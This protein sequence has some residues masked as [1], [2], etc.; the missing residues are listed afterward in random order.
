MQTWIDR[1]RY[2]AFMIEI[3]DRS[4]RWTQEGVP[5]VEVN[6]NDFSLHVDGQHVRLDV[7]LIM[8]HG[9]PGEDGLLQSYLDMLR[10]PYT[11]CSAFVSA[12]TF[13]KFAC[14]AF[15]AH[16]TS[17]AMANAVLVRSADDV[18]VPSIV[19]K[20][21]LPLFVKPNADGSSFGISK[22]KTAEELLPAIQKTL[23]EGSREVI[24]EEFI[25]G[26]EITNGAMFLN[27]ELTVL[28]ITEIV[29]KND[30]FDYKA[31][32]QGHSNE[33]TPAR[34]SEEIT[35]AVQQQTAQIYRQLG[36]AGIVR[37]D[38]IV[39]NNLPYFLEINTVPG[40]SRA[41]IIP[42]QVQSMG[43]DMVQTI[44]ALVETAL[45]AHL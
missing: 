1:E 37:V 9:T 40:M 5:S 10:V 29:S 44:T 39:H 31:K 24:V 26:I 38:Y 12:L 11:T 42:Q 22:V 18:D 3:K 27:G 17:V 35:Q 36:C 7:A 30:F 34:L 23:A 2:N 41:S 32:Y 19:A 16:T 13:N 20:L 15:L 4:W 45:A 33:I 6:K 43:G 8:I 28:P 14:K 25:E 21:G